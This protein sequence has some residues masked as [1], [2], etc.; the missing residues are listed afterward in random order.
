[1]E[2]IL[3]ITIQKSGR[4]SDQSLS[5]LVRAGLDIPSNGRALRSRCRNFPLEI[6]YL[7]AKDSLEVIQDGLADIGILGQNTLAESG[8]KGIEEATPLVLGI[9]DF[10]LRRLSEAK[11]QRSQT[12]PEKRLPRAIP[13][14]CE[15]I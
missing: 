15:N 8:F 3:R 14:F 12:C 7:R 2:P 1:M 9:V 6:L 11:L 5:L 10:A 13:V 4:L